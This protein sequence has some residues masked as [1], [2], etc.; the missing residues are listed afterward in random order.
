MTY[1]HHRSLQKFLHSLSEEIDV[2]PAKYRDAKERYDAVGSWLG[3]E[4]SALA[5]YKPTIYPQGSFALGTAV[6]PLGDD[7]YDVDAVCLLE[8]PPNPITQQLLKRLVGDRLKHPHSRYRGMVDPPTGG[9]RCWTIRYADASKFHLDVLPAIPDD[10]LWLLDL[11]VPRDWAETA[12]RLTDSKTWDIDPEWP[13]SNPKGFASWFRSRMETQIRE[14]KIRR[15][16]EIKAEAEEIPDYEVRTPLQRLVQLLKRHRDIHYNGDPDKPVSIIITTLAA[17]A[18]GDGSTLLDALQRVVPEMRARIVRR[19]GKWWVANPVNPQENFADK[20]NERGGARKVTVFQDWL[21]RLERE[22]T[23]VLQATDLKSV[24]P[25]LQAAFGT[26]DVNSAWNKC[27][28]ASVGGATA[29][30][31][32]VTVV[33]PPVTDRPP[34][35]RVELP[36]RPNRPWKP[37]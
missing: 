15:A 9:R 34:A 1:H 6:R 19:G 13:R 4:D 24:G 8:R 30:T 7:D 12:I 2:S 20:W 16:M 29:T 5:A 33:V 17:H 22:W 3:Q 10:F 21:Q 32:G 35:P 18:Y 26:R 27:F 11:G 25:R 36:S 31:A 37:V 23:E 14:A 28:G